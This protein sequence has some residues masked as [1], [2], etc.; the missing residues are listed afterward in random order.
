MPE[1]PPL[2]DDIG[3]TEPPV[4]RRSLTLRPEPTTPL[5]KTQKAFNRLVAK[6]G[7]LRTRL[8]A[9][10]RRLEEALVYH[11]GHLRPRIELVVSTRS[12]VVRALVPFLD[13]RRLKKGDIGVLRA[14]LMDQLDE[15]L[16]HAE[17]VDD[18]LRALFER[19]HGVDMKEVEAAKLEDARAEIEAMF[20]ELGADVDLSGFH[21]GMSE[22]DLAARAAELA[23]ELKRQAQ[24]AEARTRSKRRKTKR[25]QR[26]QERQRRADEARKVSIGSIYRQL[27]KVL[28]PDLE[29]DPDTRQRKSA[30]MQEVTAAYGR[31]DLH[32]LLRLQI[33]WIHHE[34]ADTARLTN[35]RL[36]AY[37]RV[38]REQVAQLEM[39]LAALPLHPKYEPLTED[40]SPFGVRVRTD[41]PA[42]ARRLDEIAEDLEGALDSL[43]GPHALGNVRALIRDRRAAD[44]ARARMPFPSSY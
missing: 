22:R 25:E 23:G 29:Q 27:A 9:D 17:V 40:F 42:E 34:G 15:V 13:D 7:R 18:D 11:A 37:N 26:E 38:L 20:A 1:Q 12:E 5:T 41:G 8:E 16:A 36:D 28:H 35:E 2:F 24:D 4:V 19:L 31:Q 30:L 43:Q 6:V 3:S 32:A 10:R 21:A 44:K 14:M 33:Q 39:E